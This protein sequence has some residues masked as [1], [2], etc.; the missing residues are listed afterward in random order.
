MNLTKLLILHL[1]QKQHLVIT[2]TA[3]IPVKKLQMVQ[4][5]NVKKAMNWVPTV[6]PVLISMNAN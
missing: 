6:N 4:N 2:I 3:N 5:V 1:I